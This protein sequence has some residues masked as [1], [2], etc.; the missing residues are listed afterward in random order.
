MALDID[1][2]MIFFF[3]VIPIMM[4]FM[5]RIIQSRFGVLCKGNL[6]SKVYEFIIVLAILIFNIYFVFNYYKD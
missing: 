1:N 2:L 3:I 6:S 5:K 4:I